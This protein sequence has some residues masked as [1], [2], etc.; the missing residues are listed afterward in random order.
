VSVFVQPRRRPGRGVAH[1]CGVLLLLLAFGAVARAASCA[2]GVDPLRFGDTVT[3]LPPATVGKAY[4][5]TLGADGGVPPYIFEAESLPPGLAL[6]AAGTLKGEPGTLPAIA[7][8]TAAVRDHRGCVAQQKFRLVVRAAHRSGYVPR[9]KPSAPEAPVPKPQPKPKPKPKPKPVEPAPLTVVPLADTLA[10]PPSNQPSMN[11]YML[12]SAVFKDK[13]VVAQLKQMSA[14]IAPAS[15]T[16][17][18]L[19][20]DSASSSALP[21]D[22]VSQGGDATLDVDT[23]AQFKRLLQPL[24]GVEYPG[25]DLFEAALDTRLCRFSTMLV[26]AVARR[27]GKPAPAM[28]AQDCPPDWSKLDQDDNYR[29]A[30][31]VPW[32]DVPLSL[33]SPALRAT[34]IEKARQKHELLDPVAPSWNGAGCGCVRHLSGKVYG[35]YPFWR[36]QDKPQ[37]LDFSLLSRISLFALWYRDTGD[38]AVPEWQTPQQTAFIRAAR[39]HRTQID[40]TLYRNDWTFLEKASD[41]D[42]ER[43]ANRLAVQAADFIDT[44]LADLASRSHAWVPGFATVER[45]GDGLTFFPDKVPSADSSLGPA[46]RRYVNK[47]ITAFIEELRKRHRHYALNIVL[48]DSDLESATGVWK[49]AMLYDYI[50]SAE[51]P[52]LKDGH[53][54]VGSARYHS[55]TNVTLRYL[56]LLTDPTARSKRALRAIVDADKDLDEDDHRVLLRKMIPVVSNGDAGRQEITNEMAY[57][58]DNFG[59]VGFWAA[60]TRDHAAGRMISSGIRASFLTKVPEAERFHGWI[61]ANRWLLRI[62]FEALLISWLVAFLVYRTNCRFRHLS[63]RLVLLVAAV[64]ILVLGALLLAGDPALTALR[65]GNA[66]LGVLLVALIATIAYHMLKPWV[67]KP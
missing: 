63:Y 15:S 16:A 58:A 61:C 8:F 52:H 44:P 20:P 62:A 18:A 41:S 19:D 31:P 34:L 65:E 39:R 28:S 4:D 49:V 35:F 42:T 33:M 55:N 40:Y 22:D 59:G 3:T 2:D 17:P 56:V 36:T 23:Q 38:L 25:R 50:K 48:R 6:S 27:E 60:P 9:P 5:Y 13:D 45:M 24:I 67:E 21:G 11:T 29:P 47:Q 43:F 37:A 51:D 7:V 46:F 53:I 14:N 12:T 54:V 26:R 57:F 64:C 10:K 30:D 1:G 32:K 66:L